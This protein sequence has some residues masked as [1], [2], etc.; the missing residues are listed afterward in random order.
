[1]TGHAEPTEDD[2]PMSENE[3]L[4]DWPL[5]QCVYTMSTGKR[6]PKEARMVVQCGSPFVPP[7]KIP[8][9][10]YCDDH[11][12]AVTKPRDQRVHKTAEPLIRKQLPAIVQPPAPT[13]E[14]GR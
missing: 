5:G 3:N 6:C 8:A 10:G 9:Y 14:R 1:M 2:E 4:N 13:E 7:E 12:F 11:Y